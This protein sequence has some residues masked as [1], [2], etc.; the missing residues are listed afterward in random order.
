MSSDALW[1][2]FAAVAGEDDDDLDRLCDRLDGE[3]SDVGTVRRVRAAGPS[4]GK[5]G[6]DLALTALMLLTQLTPEIIGFVLEI[7]R[8]VVAQDPDRRISVRIGEHEVEVSL[9]GPTSD[10]VSRLISLAEEEVRR[11]PDRGSDR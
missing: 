2:E 4:S 3:L 11:R 10:E 5:S 9:D 7:L 6:T 8:G 1:V